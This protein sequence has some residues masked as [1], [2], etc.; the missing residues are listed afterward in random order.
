M[1]GVR[2]FLLQFKRNAAALPF[3]L[4]ISLLL[5]GAIATLFVGMAASNQ[6]SEEQ[7]KFSIAIVGDTS[8]S[9]LGIGVKT[10]ETLDSSR[11]TIDFV[12]MTEP[13]AKNALENSEISAYVVIPEGFIDAMVSGEVMQLTYVTGPGKVDLTTMFKE[14]LAGFISDILLHSQKGIYGLGDAMYS[15]GLKNRGDAM[16]KASLEYFD[17]ILRRSDIYKVEVLGIADQ[18]SFE[19]YF[20]CGFTVFFLLLWG[21]SCCYV[22]AKRDVSLSRVLYT[23]GYGGCKQ[24]VGEYLSYFLIMF[25]S[26]ALI[27]LCC[28]A[29]VPFIGAVEGI[30][31]GRVLRFALELVP[32]IIMISALQYMLYELVRTLVGSVLIQFVCAMTLGYAGGCLYPVSFFPKGMQSLAEFLPSGIARGYL[33]DCLTESFSVKNALGLVVCTFVFLAISVVVRRKRIVGRGGYEE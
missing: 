14:E 17:K 7:S 30:G 24:V 23:H 2:Y 1:K 5:F 18:L 15:E 25:I 13:D 6:N 4:V 31:V 16:D 19:Q 9:Y 28:A 11:F 27:V 12:E 22:F 29:A 26:I 10:I 20:F 32:V 3:V 8:D 33:A 21:I